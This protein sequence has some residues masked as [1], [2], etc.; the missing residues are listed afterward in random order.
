MRSHNIPGLSIAIAAC[1]AMLIT[2]HGA[3]QSEPT[4]VLSLDVAR[5][6]VAFDDMDWSIASA[7][8]NISLHQLKIRLG[9]S[10]EKIVQR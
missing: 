4:T 9:S 3:A 1:A 7:V 6:S 5:P 10:L 8:V 2:S